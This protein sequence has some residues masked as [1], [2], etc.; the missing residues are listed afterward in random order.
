MTWNSR[1]PNSS[2]ICCGSPDSIAS[3]T[4]YAS[5][6]VEGAIV[7]NVCSISQGQPPSGLLSRA[8]TPR[9]RSMGL[10]SSAIATF[11]H[12]QAI[13]REDH[14]GGRSPDVVLPE[15]NVDNVDL[16]LT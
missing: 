4:S 16:A 2:R 1:S 9:R 11:L 8:M 12:A 14:A 7:S 10:E 13:E 15:G 5:S 3:A 6:I